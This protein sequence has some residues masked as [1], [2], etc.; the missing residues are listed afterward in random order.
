MKNHDFVVVSKIRKELKKHG[1]SVSLETLE[2]LSEA[3]IQ[4][5]LKASELAKKNKR[6][7]I[8]KRDLD[9]SFD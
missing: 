9:G 3:L 7:V 1:M 6:K 5:L 4:R 2:Y 8:K